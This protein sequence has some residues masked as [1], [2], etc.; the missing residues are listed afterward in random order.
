MLF[1]PYFVSRPHL[2]KALLMVSKITYFFLSWQE[3]KSS[4]YSKKKAQTVW[5]SAPWESEK[6]AWMDYDEKKLSHSI[7]CDSLTCIHIDGQF[8]SPK[9]D[10]WKSKTHTSVL[11]VHFHM[12]WFVGLSW[13]FHWMCVGCTTLEVSERSAGSGLAALRM[14]GRCS[15]WCRSAVMTWPWWRTPPW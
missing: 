5:E 2:K 8:H 13:L 15:L 14:S 11:S 7:L 4:M 6:Y 9:V 3:N 12:L 1:L 10:Q